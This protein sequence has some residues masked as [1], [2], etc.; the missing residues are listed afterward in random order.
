[1]PPFGACFM[2]SNLKIWLLT[3]G[4]NLPIKDGIR[5]ERTGML[6]DKLVERNHEV[7]WWT[8]AFSHYQK[9]WFFQKD[10]NIK[11]N[12]LIIKALKGIGYKK[13]ISIRRLV[14]HRIIAWKFKKIAPR[15]IQPDIIIAASPSYDLAYQAVIFSKKNNIPILIDIRDEWP[16]LFLNVFP[17]KY[18]NFIKTI[19]AYDFRMI[20]ETMCMSDGLIAMMEPLLNW[21]LK[22]AARPKTENDRIFYLGGKKQV[23]KNE[24]EKNTKFLN[25]I[26]NKFVITFIGTFVRNNNPSIL[27]NCAEK[28][29][30]S[31]IVFIIA[32]NGEL[33]DEIRKRAKGLSNV[34]LPGWLDQDEIAYLLKHS[35]VGVCPAPQIRNAFPNKA[36]S[37]L[38]A[39]LPII[40]AFQGDLKEIIEK[41]EIGFYYPP[42]DA[43]AL[44]K[45]MKKFYED[46]GLYKK[47]SENAYKVFIKMFD[48]DKIYD[49]YAEHIEKV[50]DDYKKKHFF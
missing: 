21:G 35:H 30:N 44:L 27:T 4:E 37:Y 34:F 7:L 3:I 9:V 13:N 28:L 40:S 2:T 26:D 18:K 41:H 36:F 32:G 43:E 8:S 24:L 17:K 31:N 10:T 22:Y 6:A 48:A 46:T 15:M 23:I 50:A 49:E 47:M 45:C 29:I 1:M 16:D 11:K 33:F 14:D 39:G 19:L 12:G 38:A 5:K 42:N 25:F 20:N